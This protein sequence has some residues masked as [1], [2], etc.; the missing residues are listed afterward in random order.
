MH[1]EC[2]EKIK[3]QKLIAQGAGP[4]EAY[5]TWGV[6]PSPPRGGC[7]QAQDSGTGGGPRLSGSENELGCRLDDARWHV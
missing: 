2:D 4:P 6:C 5:C 3:K 1:A 7:G